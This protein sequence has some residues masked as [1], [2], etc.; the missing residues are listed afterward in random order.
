M[1]ETRLIVCILLG[2]CVPALALAG[3]KPPSQI[4]TQNLIDFFDGFNGAYWKP[5]S[6]AKRAYGWHGCLFRGVSSGDTNGTYL[7]AAV[8]SID[9]SELFF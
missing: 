1:I 4:K 3:L 6:M 9:L 8:A 5:R 7:Y 2:V